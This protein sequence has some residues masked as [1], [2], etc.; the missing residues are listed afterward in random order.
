MSC[1]SVISDTGALVGIG[2]GKLI[3]FIIR[4][5]DS[6]IVGSCREG[7]GADV[8]CNDVRAKIVL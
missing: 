4:I 5:V 7:T 3:G 8:E 1:M 6:N 2:W